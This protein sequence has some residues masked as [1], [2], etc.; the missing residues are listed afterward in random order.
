MSAVS[1]KTI[2]YKPRELHGEWSVIRDT[3]RFGFIDLPKNDELIQTELNTATVK[4]AVTMLNIIRNHLYYKNRM[5]QM[6]IGIVE[7]VMQF[8]TLIIE[9][10]ENQSY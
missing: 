4:L 1:T 3:N 6:R 2:C 10:Q 5:C 9:S 7:I 8:Q